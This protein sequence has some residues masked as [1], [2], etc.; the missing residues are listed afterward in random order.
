MKP[1]VKILLLTIALFAHILFFC[2]NFIFGV[3]YNS[4]SFLS[5]LMIFDIIPLYYFVK[6]LT[7]G[8]YSKK[9]VDGVILVLFIIL[10]ILFL[11]DGFKGVIS[12][13]FIAYSMPSA[14]IGIIL[15]KCDKEAY[16]AKYLEPIMLLIT[17]ASIAGLK[18]GLGAGSML[19]VD[20]ENGMGMQSLSYYTAF[21]F[22]LNLYFLLLGDELE[23]RF[24]YTKTVVYKVFSVTLLV[25]Q[26]V[27]VLSSG[28]R[29]GSVLL[30]LSAL[31]IV[32][33]KLITKK[34]R[35]KNMFFPFL[36]ISAAIVLA[37]NFMPE[38]IL[39]LIS[40]GQDRAFSYLSNGGI[41]MSETSNRDIVYADAI[42]AITDSPIIGYGLLMK[43]SK[44]EGT[45][46][47]N[48]ILEILLQGGFILLLIFSFIFIKF[49]NKL[50]RMI[51]KGHGHYILPIVLYPIVMLCFSGSY[52]STGLFWFSLAYVFVW[53]ATY[54]IYPSQIKNH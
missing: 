47:H 31:M 35:S 49:L 45:W 51:R 54:D 10:F 14:L 48:L 25:V 39:N 26:L 21:A 19:M 42:G 3:V 32:F 43:G 37:V 5:F 33:L 40:I 13:S 23:N 30:I 20:T 46:P 17:S 38:N 1:S 2:Y 7:S 24:R 16:F 11:E 44:F 6:Y 50:V 9:N 15:A 34:G 52:I 28:G 22:S 12:R 53:D 27:S 18:Y 29:G 41:D 36:L 8:S 4:N